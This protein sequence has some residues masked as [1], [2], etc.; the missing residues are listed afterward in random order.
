METKVCNRCKVELPLSA[1]YINKN[2]RPRWVCKNCAKG[3]SAERW[4]SG[5]AKPHPARRYSEAILAALKGS[6][7]TSVEIRT[8]ISASENTFLAAIK[9]DINRGAVV[10]VRNGKNFVYWLADEYRPS[11][12]IPQDDA[13]SDVMRRDQIAAKAAQETAWLADVVKSGQRFSPFGVLIS[14]KAKRSPNPII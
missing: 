8:K 4:K 7:S 5:A 3:I 11:K 2:G 1:Y 12:E 6:P 10:R 9:P 14:A 13:A